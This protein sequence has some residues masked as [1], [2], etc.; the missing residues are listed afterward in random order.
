MS[1]QSTI[2][3][4]RIINEAVSR[5]LGGLH[6][7][8]I[9]LYSLDFGE[10]E[11]LQRQGDWETA[12]SLL[13]E[14][15]RSLQR[16]GAD[17]VLICA[18]TMHIVAE[19]VQQAVRIP[20]VHVA[21][22]TAAGIRRAGLECVGLLGT[23]Y[24]MEKHFLKQRLASHGLKVIIPDEEDRITVHRVIFEELCR[25]KI[26]TSSRQS[27]VDMVERMAERGA[28][29]VILGCTE[30]SLLIR[31]EDLPLPVFDTTVIHA[32]S[33]VEMALETKSDEMKS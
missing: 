1:W 24:T 26:L 8:R 23:R 27:L 4:Y 25:G 31:P 22:V 14:A 17:F 10:I 13:A 19:A 11:K 7:A 21:D 15:A 18:N 30:L 16:A 2:E 12:G 33:A 32:E 6:S 29:G 20:V 28:E 9:V 5:R 3:Y